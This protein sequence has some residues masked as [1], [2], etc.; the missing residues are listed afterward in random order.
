MLEKSKT[1]LSYSFYYFNVSNSLFL[2]TRFVTLYQDFITFFG[3]LGFS[4]RL[5]SFSASSSFLFCFYFS[6][7]LIL[8]NVVIIFIH[9]ALNAI[10]IV[11]YSCY[12]CYCYHSSVLS[13]IIRFS[14]VLSRLVGVWQFFSTI[15][16]NFC[17]FYPFC[18][19]FYSCKSCHFFL[20]I[21]VNIIIVLLRIIWILSKGDKHL[22]KFAFPKSN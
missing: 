20:L 1:S 18:N 19:H 5:I 2:L 9:E 7:I 14:N 8:V 3:F 22:T 16:L 11:C 17:H 10:L 12:S 4:S 21:L 15:L 13:I 6:A